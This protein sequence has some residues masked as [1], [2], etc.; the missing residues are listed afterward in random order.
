[1]GGKPNVSTATGAAVQ[2]GVH[3]SDCGAFQRGQR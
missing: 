2:V 1:M 3:G